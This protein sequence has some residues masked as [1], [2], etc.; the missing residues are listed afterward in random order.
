M[1]ILKEKML[2][3]HLAI[4]ARSLTLC[5]K[6]EKRREVVATENIKKLIDT[7][8]KINIPIFSLQ[9]D[10]STDKDIKFLD[11]LLS[12]LLHDPLIN[13]NKIKIMFI[14]KWFDL[15]IAITENMKKIM[16]ETND[17]DKFFL[18]FLVKYDG[19][20]EVTSAIKLLTLKAFNKQLEVEKITPEIIKESLFSSYF[21]PPDLIIQCG[22]R[23]S[24]ILLW[25]S[26]GAVIY[27]TKNKHWITFDTKEL[28]FALAKY[29]KAMDEEK[30]FFVLKKN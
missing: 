4:A 14:G 10:T 18:N 23:Y 30:R 7:Q 9:L 1:D 3:K 19:K 24:G 13:N 20:D 26:P 15:P 29:K 2:P 12:E 22:H 17:Y 21:L 6:Q 28:D 27:F 5:E 11:E 8:V 25:D 16:E